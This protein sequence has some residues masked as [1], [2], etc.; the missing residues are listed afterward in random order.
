MFDVR[1]ERDHFGRR[2]GRG[3]VLFE[4]GF[5]YGLLVAGERRRSVRWMSP[6]FMCVAL[7]WR[8]CVYGCLTWLDT[9]IVRCVAVA[10][11][12]RFMLF[13]VV[14]ALDVKNTTFRSISSCTPKQNVSCIFL[15]EVFTRKQKKIILF[16]PCVK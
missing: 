10:A 4:C 1:F 8:I 15:W 9:F 3:C 13:V 14:C 11:R 16:F 7:D 6:L 12:G 2:Y 5:H